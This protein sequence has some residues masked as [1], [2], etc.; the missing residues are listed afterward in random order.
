MGI[1]QIR[2][3]TICSEIM[4]DAAKLTYVRLRKCIHQSIA[5]ILIENLRPGTISLD[6]GSVV[7]NFKKARIQRGKSYLI[8]ELLTNRKKKIT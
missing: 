4:L 1:S 7:R 6:P 8:N 5:S 3:T 2:Y